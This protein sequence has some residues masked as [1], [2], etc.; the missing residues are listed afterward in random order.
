MNLY[1]IE[2][3]WIPHLIYYKA[4]LL[5]WKMVVFD[6]AAVFDSALGQS[7]CLAFLDWPCCHPCRNL[8][9]ST[10]STTPEKR[11][12]RHQNKEA[13]SER[14]KWIYE[15]RDFGRYLP[16]FTGGW[17]LKMLRSILHGKTPLFG[18]SCC[19]V[20]IAFARPSN[21]SEHVDVAIPPFEKVCGWGLEPLKKNLPQIT[22][23][24]DRSM[25]YV[26]RCT[27]YVYII[28]MISDRP[29]DPC[30]HS[31]KMSTSAICGR[32]LDSGETLM[33]LFQLDM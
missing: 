9:T 19:G 13:Y 28:S 15:A 2:E 5:N 30:P 6:V 29:L 26:V 33:S 21:T 22:Q 25:T 32:L 11:T 31:V 16:F 24:H 14:P 8:P 20:N 7:P 3:P 4:F 23:H 17:P 27:L 1:C 12:C 18:P 10:K